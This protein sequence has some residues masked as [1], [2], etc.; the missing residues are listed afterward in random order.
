MKVINIL[1]LSVLC[2]SALAHI[3]LD[4]QPEQL[5]RIAEILVQNYVDH[6]LVTGSI[7]LHFF[8]AM[9]KSL[10]SLQ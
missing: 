8:S 3:V 6:N 4:I 1:I 10:A 9:L 5:Q 2:S 7:K